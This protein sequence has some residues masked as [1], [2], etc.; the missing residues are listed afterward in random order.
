MPIPSDEQLQKYADQWKCGYDFLGL[1]GRKAAIEL[2]AARKVVEAARKIR[3]LIA[4]KQE[5]VLVG[6]LPAPIS[7]DECHMNGLDPALKAYDS[8]CGG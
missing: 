6:V 5:Q 3:R 1:Y 8:A 7:Y 2:I 4:F